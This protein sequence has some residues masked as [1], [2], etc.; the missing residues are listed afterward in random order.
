MLT[1]PS[2]SVQVGLE[3]AEISILAGQALSDALTRTIKD[4]ICASTSGIECHGSSA[5]GYAYVYDD[6][7]KQLSAKLNVKV[8]Q[9]I[10]PRQ[11][12]VMVSYLYFCF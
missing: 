12:S 7:E 10:T 3:L 8:E 11:N 6:A 2:A 5:I 1:I 9:E 4:D